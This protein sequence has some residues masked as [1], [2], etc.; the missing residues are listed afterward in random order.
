VTL[1]RVVKVELQ[2]GAVVELPVTVRRARC[3]GDDCGHPTSEETA[4]LI[5]L[6]I[7]DAE[8]AGSQGPRGRDGRG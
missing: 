5:R 1:G 2:C 8:L 3:R 7:L 4:D 6:A